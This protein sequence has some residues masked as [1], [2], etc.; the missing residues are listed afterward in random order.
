MNIWVHIFK[1]TYVFHISY[2]LSVGV[3]LLGP[4]ILYT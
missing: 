1:W 2:E 3:K 4:M